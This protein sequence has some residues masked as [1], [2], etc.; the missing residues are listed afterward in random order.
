L[1]RFLKILF[2]CSYEYQVYLFYSFCCHSYINTYIIFSYAKQQGFQSRCGGGG[3]DISLF[4]HIISLP[5]L[6]KAWK[7]FKKS[8]SSKKDV[9]NFEFNLENNL[10]A[11]NQRLLDKTYEPSPYEAFFV[12]DPKKRHIH[13]A[14]VSDRVLYQAVYRIIYPIFDKHFIYDSYSSRKEKG[15]H[16]ASK[17]LFVFLRKISKNWNAPVFALKCDVRKFFDSINHDVLFSLISKKIKDRDT[18]NLIESIFKSFEKSKGVGL[19]L[20]NVTSQLFANIYLNE[21]DQFIKHNLKVKYYLRY[22][23]DFII[24]NNNQKVLEAVLLKLKEFLRVNLKLE[25]HPNKIS[26]RKLHQ[27][28]DFVGYVI[29]KDAVVLRTKTKKRIY[30]KLKKAKKDLQNELLDKEKFIQIKNSYLG[31]LKHCKDKEIKRQIS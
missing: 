25:L 31:I 4:N 17:R 13:K 12:Y 29:L 20:G 15:V 27:G 26:I 23:D 8:K 11:L 18:L 6:L 2:L 21:L 16:T 14:N 28:I 3:S 9:F 24:L 22:A 30:K 7:E 10:F 1:K 5:N 19:P